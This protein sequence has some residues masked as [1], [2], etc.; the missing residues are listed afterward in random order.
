[1]K[2]RK[3]KRQGMK[4]ING[5]KGKC[6]YLYIVQAEFDGGRLEDM[7]VLPEPEVLSGNESIHPAGRR[8][9]SRRCMGA[10]LVPLSRKQT[11]FN[12]IKD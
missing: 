9:W 6:F 12:Q 2:G 10:D 1:M 8:A 4:K 5:K 11:I 7:S 3:E